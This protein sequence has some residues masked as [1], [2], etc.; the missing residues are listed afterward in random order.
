MPEWSNGAVSKTVVLLAGTG[1]SNPFL[2]AKEGITRSRMVVGYF[3]AMSDEN[4]FSEGNGKKI[5]L[6]AACAKGLFL[7]LLVPPPIG[8]TYVIPLGEINPH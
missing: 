3:F 5:P 8:I 4:L 6:C 2:S 7:V 1:G